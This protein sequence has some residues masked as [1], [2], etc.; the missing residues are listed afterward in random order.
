MSRF[1]LPWSRFSPRPGCILSTHN[2][3]K[4]CL[5]WVQVALSYGYGDAHLRRLR[6]I[7]GPVHRTGSEHVLGAALPTHASSNSRMPAAPLDLYR[8]PGHQDR[9]A[10]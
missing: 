7:S 5:G 4:F 8:V 2:D 9:V 3:T 10:H 6:Q 1:V